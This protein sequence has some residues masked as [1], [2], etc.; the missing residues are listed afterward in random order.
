MEMVQKGGHFLGIA[1][2]NNFMGLGFYQFSPELYSS[3]FARKNGFMI[4]RITLFEESL[5]GKWYEIINP[6]KVWKHSEII[7]KHKTYTFVQARKIDT[8]L[9]FSSIPQQS[10]YLLLWSDYANSTSKNRYPYPKNG[11]YRSS[12]VQKV[13]DGIKKYCPEPVKTIYRTI[14]RATKPRFDPEFFKKIDIFKL[15][16]NK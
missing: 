8:V 16:E 14:I 5:R 9:I 10:H 15:E 4:D 3:I 7:S 12:M 13:F 6:E 2:A 11:E 1:P